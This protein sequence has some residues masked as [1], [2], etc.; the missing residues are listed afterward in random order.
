MTT[1]FTPGPVQV[2]PD[3]LRA[4]SLPLMHHRSDEF[5]Q[6]SSTVWRN[7]QH[8]FCTESTVLIV[9][10]SGMTGI[11][12]AM[13]C[14]LNSSDTIIVINHGRFSE[15]LVTI[16]EL[17]GVTVVEVTVPWGEHVN[18]EHLESVLTS[19]SNCKALWMV[20]GETSTG[21]VQPLKEISGL[22]R[23]VNPEMLL[24]VDAVLTVGVEPLMFDEWKIDIAVTATQKGLQCV[25]G[26]ACIALSA[27]AIALIKCMRIPSFCM[28]L[29]TYLEEY[30]IGSF[31]YTPPVTL[32][33][34]LDVALQLILENG[35]QAMYDRQELRA[36]RIKN[37]LIELGY[38]FFGLSNS[39]SVLLVEHSQPKQLSHHLK[40]NYGISVSGGQQHLRGKIIRIGVMGDISAAAEQQLLDGMKSFTLAPT[41]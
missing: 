13:V 28:N 16:A 8:V 32:V 11:E 1:L 18:L 24:C 30:E 2:H 20:H 38:T 35:L 7:L 25:P 12:A 4:S 31:P 3:V 10:G 36:T 39:N 27:R 26:A 15:R 6:L 14:T 22:V 41:A 40:T 5:K 21:V 33:R 23:S 9:P 17:N 19:H 34:C 29:S 37:A